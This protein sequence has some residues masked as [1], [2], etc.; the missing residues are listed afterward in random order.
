MPARVAQ[1]HSLLLTEAAKRADSMN[2]QVV[3]G[4]LDALRDAHIHDAHHGLTGHCF[5][6]YCQSLYKYV[7][8]KLRTHKMKKRLRWEDDRE[9]LM[10]CDPDSFRSGLIPDG[11]KILDERKEHAKLLRTIKNQTKDDVL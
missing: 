2:Q 8:Y 7:N 5:C 1:M 6:S 3:A 9:F 10:S 4:V 11:E